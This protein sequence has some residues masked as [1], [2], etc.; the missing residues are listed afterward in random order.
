[1]KIEGINLVYANP[2]NLHSKYVTLLKSLTVSNKSSGIIINFKYPSINDKESLKNEGVDVS[3]THFIDGITL[4]ADLI[5]KEEDIYTLLNLEDLGGVITGV[6]SILRSDGNAGFLVID[7]LDALQ[8][9]NSI[10]KIKQMILDIKRI[11]TSKGFPA[12][13]FINE[14]N[15]TL[16]EGISD[17]IDHR[18]VHIPS[19]DIETKAS[20]LAEYAEKPETTFSNEKVSLSPME[21]DALKEIGNIGSGNASTDLSKLISQKINISLTNLNIVPTDEFFSRF[22]EVE[23]AHVAATFLRVSGDITG[24]IVTMFNKD[25]AARL[26]DMMKKQAPG[27]MTEINEESKQ[28][29]TKVGLD[30]TN[31]YL[32][33][34]SQFLGIKVALEDPIFAINKK[35]IILGFMVR[36]IK[37]NLQRD[38]LMINT[39][40]EVEGQDLNGEFMLIFGLGSLKTFQELIRTKLGMQ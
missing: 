12:F 21:I 30:V 22:H 4:I 26:V 37:S 14:A 13:I 27:T 40:F 28:Y 9:Y 20:G 25:K 36:L 35:N 33:A 39:Q 2:G 6:E 7:I 15:N 29:V 34:L 24:S 32:N 38:I 31:A 1:M 18:F 10:Q 16:I 5:P 3:K 17:A 11:A 8:F 19:L 23:Q